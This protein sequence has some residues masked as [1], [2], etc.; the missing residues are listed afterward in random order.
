[1]SRYSTTTFNKNVV[2]A[3]TSYQILEVLQLILRSG[4]GLTSSNED[5]SWKKYNEPFWGVDNNIFIFID[6]GVCVLCQTSK[7]D[8]FSLSFDYNNICSDY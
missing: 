6:F 7:T 5:F 8:Y 1:M 4:E 2:V 3:K